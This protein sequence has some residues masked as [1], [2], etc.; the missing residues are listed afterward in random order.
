MHVYCILGAIIKMIRLRI[1]A[2]NIFFYVSTFHSTAS[3][4][5][6]EYSIKQVVNI[7]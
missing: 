5:V 7:F 2:Q 1:S 4:F 6:S 3:E